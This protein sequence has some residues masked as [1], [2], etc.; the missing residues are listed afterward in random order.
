MRSFINLHASPIII[1]VIKARRVRWKGHVAR[2]GEMINAYNIFVG[3]LDGKR[4]L[5]RRA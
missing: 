1:R 4:P 2:K 3:K 5:G